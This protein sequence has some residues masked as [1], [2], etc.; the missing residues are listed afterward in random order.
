MKATGRLVYTAAALC[1]N[2]ANKVHMLNLCISFQSLKENDHIK[3]HDKCSFRKNHCYFLGNSTISD[4]SYF[5][6]IIS[7]FQAIFHPMKTKG[8][9][10]R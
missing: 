9:A 5:I 1:Q 2:I 7:I 8:R 3:S 4:C 6:M 10:Q